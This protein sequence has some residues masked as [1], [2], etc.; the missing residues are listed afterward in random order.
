MSGNIREASHFDQIIDLVFDAVLIIE[1][2][3]IIFANH[4]ANALLAGH[5]GTSVTDAFVSQFL[6]APSSDELKH[7]AAALSA[8][9]EE[10]SNA[11]YLT[12]HNSDGVTR[13]TEGRVRRLPGRNT[14]TVLLILKDLSDQKKI[15]DHL[16]QASKLSM[17]GEFS[18]GIIH[19]IKNPL[20]AIKGFLQLMQKEPVINREYLTILL[21]EV[22]NIEKITGELLYFARP[23]T[24]C[25]ELQNLKSISGEVI[26]LFQ[27]LAAEKNIRLIIQYDNSPHQI[28]GDRTKLKQMFIN[29]IKNA[30]EASFENSSVH[31]ILKGNG[32]SESVS[33][34]NRGRIIPEEIQKHLGR[35]FITTKE[36]GTGLGLM[37]I[38]TIVRDHHGK[39]NVVSNETSGT[40]FTLTFPRAH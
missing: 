7:Q 10:S 29:L 32:P 36:T 19:E 13:F 38:C 22:E 11:F 26:H 24:G 4:S 9:T 27:S 12:V 21:K 17:I 40:L 23:K 5:P 25:F 35:S 18:A 15:E 6:D 30:I 34:Q 14:S 1:K 39:I 31:V 20:T 16:L 37:M 2:G 28:M 33:I 8:D 3:R